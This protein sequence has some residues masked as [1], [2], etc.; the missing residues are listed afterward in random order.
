MILLIIYVMLYQIFVKSR[1]SET[2]ITETTV[3][4]HYKH[5]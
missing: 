2:D 3:I 1:K 4:V 5:F